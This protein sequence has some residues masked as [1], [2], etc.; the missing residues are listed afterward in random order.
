M[1]GFSVFT[2][3]MLIGLPVICLITLAVYFIYKALYNRHANRALEND[4]SK[5][6]K[7][8]VAPFVVVIITVLVQVLSLFAI[9]ISAYLFQTNT[10]SSASSGIT[11]YINENDEYVVNCDEGMTVKSLNCPGADLMVYRSGR[12]IF[13]DVTIIDADKIQKFEIKSGNTSEEV[14]YKNAENEY[15]KHVPLYITLSDEEAGATLC[16]YGEDGSTTELT[17]N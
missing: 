17:L 14:L 9:G 12:D 4:G 8:W 10:K 16:V 7:K 5:K 2:I 6:S 3:L 13:V 1:V 15:S 11:Y